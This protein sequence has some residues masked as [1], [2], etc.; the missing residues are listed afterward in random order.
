[1]AKGITLLCSSGSSRRKKIP[2]T[3]SMI[4]LAGV[5]RILRTNWF[6]QQWRTQL[7]QTGNNKWTR[8][9][10]S[11][12]L[13]LNLRFLL[14]FFLY[15]FSFD[16]DRRKGKNKRQISFFSEG[17]QTISS[18]ENTKKC[19]ICRREEKSILLLPRAKNIGQTQIG[20]AIKD[21]TRRQLQE[22][23]KKIPS[24]KRQHKLHTYSVIKSTKMFL[25]IRR[26]VC[27]REKKKESN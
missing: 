24:P 1:M 2:K 8:Y 6:S 18:E 10:F 26:C 16:N 25:C 3:L 9:K 21:C 11:L 7:R 22:K 19:P 15:S 13:Y 23:Q 12:F 5:F 17:V 4:S 20:T 27:E 14:L